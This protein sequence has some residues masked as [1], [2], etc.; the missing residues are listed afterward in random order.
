MEGEKVLEQSGRV[1]AIVT[2]IVFVVS[3]IFPIS[4]AVVKDPKSIPP[5]WGMLDVVVAAILCA[6]A[7]YLAVKF[8]RRVTNEIRMTSY[9]AYRVMINVVLLLLVIFLLIGERV[10][11]TYF[12]PGIAWRTWLAF[13]AFPAWLTGFRS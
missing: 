7:I 1:I 5:W 13:Y 11:W 12:L 6:L 2:A 10:T 3:L 9:S 8:D 4:A